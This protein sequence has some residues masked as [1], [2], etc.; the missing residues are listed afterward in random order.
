MRKSGQNTPLFKDRSADQHTLTG[1][2]GAGQK[3]AARE[4]GHA[5]ALLDDTV[6]L[7]VCVLS[8]CGVC[9]VFF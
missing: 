4:A 2:H 5:A 9:F 6:P 1:F 7:C 8:R 3:L